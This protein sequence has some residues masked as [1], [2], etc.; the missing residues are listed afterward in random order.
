MFL[1][2]FT[3]FEGSLIIQLR[4]PHTAFADTYQA[5]W[6]STPL[7][8]YQVIGK[9]DL[10][11]PSQAVEATVNILRVIADGNAGTVQLPFHLRYQPPSSS[12]GFGEVLVPVPEV[13]VVTKGRCAAYHQSG[14]LMARAAGNG[15]GETETLIPVP[16]TSIDLPVEHGFWKLRVPVGHE[17]DADW[18]RWTTWLNVILGAMVIL[19]ATLRTRTREDQDKN[20]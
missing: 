14:L 6:L 13:F 3:P 1:A 2:S 15:T 7:L 16:F 19:W 5:P 18:V 17:E 20:G 12:N 8:S 10:E 9:P 4:L 11:A